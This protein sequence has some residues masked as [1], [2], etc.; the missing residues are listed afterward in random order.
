MNC[1]E[2]VELLNTKKDEMEVNKERS[3][4]MSIHV[5]KAP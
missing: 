5:E 2:W 3:R 4:A 1:K